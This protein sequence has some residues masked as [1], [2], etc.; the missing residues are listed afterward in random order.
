MTVK[1]HGLAL[2]PEIFGMV[3]GYIKREN[4]V[5]RRRLSTLSTCA[6]WSEGVIVSN[7]ASSGR[8]IDKQL[9]R[10]WSSVE[11]PTKVTISHRSIV[12]AH[13]SRH[14]HHVSCSALP[15]P[16]HKRD[17]R[18]S[19]TIT[20]HLSF[21]PFSPH[22]HCYSM[23]QSGT[24]LILDP[25]LL[26]FPAPVCAFYPL[27]I[28]LLTGSRP[29]LASYLKGL[30]KP[31][32]ALVQSL[33]EH[34]PQTWLNKSLLYPIPRRVPRR[35]TFMVHVLAPPFPHT[36]EARLELATEK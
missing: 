17:T 23:E 25:N 8:E 11:G 10:S 12:S 5:E 3:G 33:D 20:T 28:R 22:T 15:R 26:A 2:D 32:I 31:V 29:K 13:A 21:D 36:P 4:L 14:Q 7:T 19:L 1:P 9:T 18:S 27:H 30:V 16:A 35:M 6:R 34:V 24:P